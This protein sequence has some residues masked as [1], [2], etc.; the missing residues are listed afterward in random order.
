MQTSIECEN[1]D[2]ILDIMDKRRNRNP[3]SSLE[4]LYVSENKVNMMPAP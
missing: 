3:G 1:T 4:T 2:H